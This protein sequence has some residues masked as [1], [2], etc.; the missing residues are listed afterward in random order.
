MAT[1]D[2]TAMARSDSG[3]LTTFVSPE[4]SSTEAAGFMAL[5]ATKNEPIE[6]GCREEIKCGE[7][8]SRG[9]LA[10]ALNGPARPNEYRSGVSATAL[11][12]RR[13]MKDSILCSIVDGPPGKTCSISAGAIHFVG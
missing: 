10:S 11:P 5:H 8:C 6:E 13:E 12:I 4:S 7:T 1:V 2:G 9:Y 3:P